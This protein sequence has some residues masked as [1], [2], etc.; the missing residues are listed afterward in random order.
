MY[1]TIRYQQTFVKKY[2]YLEISRKGVTLW[3]IITHGTDSERKGTIG[4]PYGILRMGLQRIGN[5]RF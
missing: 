2:F 5:T 4:V 1:K 3:K